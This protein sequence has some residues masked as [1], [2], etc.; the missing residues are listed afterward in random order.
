M[1]AGLGLNEMARKIKEQLGYVCNLNWRTTPSTEIQWNQL[2]S[3]L[4]LK[5]KD[6][7]LEQ[8]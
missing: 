5:W 8:P 3:S 4:A 2:Q 6:G 1:A 7:I